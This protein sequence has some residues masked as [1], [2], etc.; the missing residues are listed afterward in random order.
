MIVYWDLFLSFT[1]FPLFLQFKLLTQSGKRRKISMAR[2]RDVK[3]TSLFTLKPYSNHNRAFWMIFP[4]IFH[5][6]IQFPIATWLSIATKPTFGRMFHAFSTNQFDSLN[7][8]N[9]FSS[10]SILIIGNIRLISCICLNYIQVNNTKNCHTI[11]HFDTNNG[12]FSCTVWPVVWIFHLCYENFH[13]LLWESLIDK[14]SGSVSLL[15]L[16]LL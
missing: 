8:Y 1:D 9:T 10:S 6:Y 3:R 16:L 12:S 2:K 15:L 7:I 14:I 4:H 5:D 13:L 11:K